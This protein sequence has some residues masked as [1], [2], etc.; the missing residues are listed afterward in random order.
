MGM[1]AMFEGHMS[2]TVFFFLLL[3]HFAEKLLML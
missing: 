2:G 1:V 3:L